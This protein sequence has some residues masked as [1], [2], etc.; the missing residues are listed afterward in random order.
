M[1]SMRLLVKI[2]VLLTI[3]AIG[4]TFG[5]RSNPCSRYRNCMLDNGDN[6]SCDF[7]DRMCRASRQ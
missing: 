7:Y 3:I 6:G 2:C 1:L 5:Q 4:L